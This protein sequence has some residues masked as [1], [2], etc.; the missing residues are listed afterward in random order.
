MK[1]IIFSFLLAILSLGAFAQDE[2][3]LTGKNGTPILPQE[4]DIAIGADALPYLNYIGNMFN[5]SS[6]NTLDLGSHNLY[7]RYYLDKNSAVKFNLSIN[8]NTTNNNYYVRDDAAY[9]LDPTSQAKVEDRQTYSNNAVNLL[10]GYMKTRGYGRLRGFYGGQVGYGFR[11]EMYEYQYGNNITAA[12]Q[13]PT[14][15]WEF[16]SNRTIYRDNGIS[17][18]IGLGGFI[19]AE[20]FFAPKICIGGEVSLMYNYYWGSQSDY[21]T[22]AWDGQGVSESEIQS[23]PGNTSSS[24]VTSRPA[25]YAGLYLMFH[26]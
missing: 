16:G 13:S 18:N 7:F 24:L 15:H 21:K 12:N 9:T 26:F 3:V 4:G 5:N 22:E 23:Q 6:N 8:N 2:E 1:K 14:N 10:V 19:G 11:R 20:Y 25:T 17:Q